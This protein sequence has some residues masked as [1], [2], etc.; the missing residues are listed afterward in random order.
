MITLLNR[1]DGRPDEIALIQSQPIVIRWTDELRKISEINPNCKLLKE[2]LG[3]DLCTPRFRPWDLVRI[4][5][6]F[7]CAVYKADRLPPEVAEATPAL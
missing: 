7:L 1:I 2:L 5:I 3:L 6:R 4:S